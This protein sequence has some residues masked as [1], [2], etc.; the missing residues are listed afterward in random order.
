MLVHIWHEDSDTYNGSKRI[1]S[2]TTQFWEFISDNNLIT[3]LNGVDIR[4]FNGNSELINYLESCKFNRDDLYYIFLD[5]VFDNKSVVK[6]MIRLENICKKHV[7]VINA[8]LLSFEYLI[9]KFVDLS[10]W[11]KTYRNNKLYVEAITVREHFIACMDNKTSWRKDKSIVE[12]IYKLCSIDLKNG[13]NIDKIHNLTSE[14]VAT[15]LLSTLTGGGPLGFQVTKTTFGKCWTCDC[16]DKCDHSMEISSK[17]KMMHKNAYKECYLNRQRFKKTS[18]A[19][20]YDLYY[21]TDAC[22]IIK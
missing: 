15:L 21:G 20:A 10:N 19:K 13:H 1:K 4:G 6:Y 3:E 18:S 7:N 17:N 16:K 9:L 14:R 12:F 5:T 22:K 2:S 11:I 8:K